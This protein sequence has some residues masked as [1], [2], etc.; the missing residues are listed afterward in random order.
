MRKKKPIREPYKHLQKKTVHVERS[1]WEDFGRIAR[2][3]EMS[4]YQYA[5]TL[6]ST[7]TFKE[8]SEFDAETMKKQQ[9]FVRAHQTEKEKV[10][11]VSLF[12]PKEEGRGAIDEILERLKRRMMGITLSDLMR[13]LIYR[14]VGHEGAGINQK[15]PIRK[16]GV[17]RIQVSFPADE[18]ETVLNNAK[19]Q[20]KVLYSYFLDLF[21]SFTDA[22]FRANHVP[23]RPGPKRAVNPDR[24]V[25]GS[26]IPEPLRMK[27]G[28]KITPEMK[29]DLVNKQTGDVYPCPSTGWKYPQEVVDTLDIEGK[30]LWP[31][32][33][34]G[35][36]AYKR[37]LYDFA[38]YEQ[39]ESARTCI[40]LY[41][42]L[43]TKLQEQAERLGVEKFEV[44]RA[45]VKYLARKL[46]NKTDAE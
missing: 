25:R 42:T 36:V 38:A 23:R 8:A 7:L 35:K 16:E 1:A 2:K 29:Y 4:S 43:Y 14:A 13:H 32:R 40:T 41:P 30:I 20:G 9:E 10:A 33:K 44:L 18:Y 24:D 22:Q 21:P 37:F 28:L 12:V 27:N 11:F 19:K 3:H 39:K 6:L 17:Q 45:F 31:T 26:W 46:E 34:N 15:E 5:L